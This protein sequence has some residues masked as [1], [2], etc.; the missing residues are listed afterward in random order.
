MTKPLDVLALAEQV[1]R[2]NHS[3]A[4]SHELL[5]AGQT[6]YGKHSEFPEYIE[7]ITPDAKRS[8]GYW[9][10]GEFEEVISML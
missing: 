9:R 1:S 7:R 6:L 2:D 3:G 4:L 5:K 10:N 8:F